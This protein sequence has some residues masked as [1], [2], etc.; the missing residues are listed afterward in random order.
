MNVVSGGEFVED[1]IAADGCL[2]ALGIERP[3]IGARICQD[4]MVSDI[5][6]CN[7]NEAK[8]TRSWQDNGLRMRRLSRACSCTN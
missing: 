1:M 3:C 5:I 8:P 2:N 6:A 4:G 7:A